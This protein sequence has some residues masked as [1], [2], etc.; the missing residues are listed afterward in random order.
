MGDMSVIG[1]IGKMG[2]KNNESL[3]N[4]LICQICEMRW[5]LEQC[6]KLIKCVKLILVVWEAGMDKAEIA[7]LSRSFGKRRRDK[8]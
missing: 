1:K 7:N 6:L 3:L 4:W 8:I 5:K 2:E